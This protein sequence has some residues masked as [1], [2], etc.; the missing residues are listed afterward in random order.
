MARHKTLR[1]RE[2]ALD[3]RLGARL[4]SFDMGDSPAPDP[5]IGQAAV[6]NAELAKEIAAFNREVYADQKGNIQKATDV[7][8]EAARTGIDLQNQ[9]K[10]I[11]ADTQDYVKGTFRPLEQQIVAGAQGYDTTERRESEAGLAQANVGSAFDQQRAAIARRQ[12]AAGIDPSSGNAQATMADMSVQQAAQQAAAG[13]A[14]RKQ[15]ETIGTARM[16]DAASLG[17]NLPSNQVAQVQSATGAGQGAVSAA[18]QPV[19]LANSTAQ[20]FNQGVNGAVG[21]NNS[22]GNLMLGQ[23]QT[24]VKAD[25]QSGLFGALGQVAGAAAGAGKLFG[26]S[27]K[28]QKKAVKKNSSE[29]SLAAIRNTPVKQW[30]YKGDSPASD[31]GKTHVGP[32]AQDVRKTMGNQTA[33]GGKAVDLISMNGHT[34]AAIQ[35]LDKKVDKLSLSMAKRGK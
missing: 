4:C 12:A 13:N 2:A 7:S 26:I 14:A 11:S 27:D 30:K 19:T 29:L 10:D 35:A 1:Q 22:A 9:Q 17:R 8:L 33:P 24:Q 16:A 34:M 20:T 31:G 18:G 3:A 6:A 23:Y 15:V 28:N 25:D 32:M 21:A 5:L